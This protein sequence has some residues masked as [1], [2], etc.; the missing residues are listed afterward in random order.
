MKVLLCAV[1]CLMATSCGGKG[2]SSSPAQQEEQYPEISAVSECGRVKEVRGSNSVFQWI[3][4][5]PGDLQK[6]VINTDA[7][8][9]SYDE[10][11]AGADFKGETTFNYQPGKFFFKTKSKNLLLSFPERASGLIENDLLGK[12]YTV[13]ILTYND[14][15]GFHDP[16]LCTKP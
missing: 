9:I 1:I 2:K 12:E 14:G 6:I 11:T 5:A 8:T 3:K 13:S 4:A 7:K 16:F 15:S 10:A